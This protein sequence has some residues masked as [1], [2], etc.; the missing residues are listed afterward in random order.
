MLQN[1]EQSRQ[2]KLRKP[3][4]T[5]AGVSP[6]A[7]MLPPR[8]CNHGTC[9]YCPTLDV[10]QSYTPLS[11]AVMRARM[12]NYDPFKQVEAR[13]KAFHAM[14]HPTDKVELI[15]MGGTF[16]EYPLKQQYEVIKRCYDALNNHNSE[17]LEEA[18]KINETAKHRCVA[19]CIE[20]RPSVCG[21]EEIKRMLDFGCTRVE[22]GV[23]R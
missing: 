4:K 19:L 14:K 16:L 21:D 17:S 12:L 13:L 20:T 18:K 7:V 2:V 10:S 23:R 22:L 5:I 15:I 8:G 1:Q 11:P 3:V 6:V 9:T